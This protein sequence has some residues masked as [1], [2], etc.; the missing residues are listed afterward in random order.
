LSTYDPLGRRITKSWQGA[1]TEYHWDHHRLAAERA[2]DGAVRVYVYADADA[3]VPFMFVDYESDDAPA[4]SGRRYFLFTNQIGAPIRVDEERGATVWEADVDPY[5]ATAVRPESTIDLA[6]RFPGHYE[7]REIGLFYNRFRHYSP[8]L[9]RYLQSDPMGAAGGVNLYAYPANPLTT[10]DLFGLHPPKDEDDEGATTTG[11]DDEEAPKPRPLTPEEEEL[12]KQLVAATRE[13]AQDII[14][15]PTRSKTQAKKDPVLTGVIDPDFPEDGP[16][17]GRNTGLPDDLVDPLAKRIEA[18]QAEVD[19]AAAEGRQIA[20]PQA[21]KPDDGHS[22][23]NALNKALK[24]RE[25]RTGQ[26]ATDA[27]IDDMIGHNVNLID[28]KAK[29]DDGSTTSIPAGT[30]CPPRCDHCRPLTSGV[31][32][33]DQ[34]G[35]VTDE[36]PKPASAPGTSPTPAGDPTPSTDPPPGG[37]PPPQTDE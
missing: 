7:D 20:K 33:V 15:D 24:N 8:V 26:P 36:P 37:D 25:D 27:D 14:D 3:L 32:M 31:R 34:N 11:K 1:T 19:K 2:P 30:G 35:Q 10:V 6:L 23:I 5:G 9:G 4:A 28:K 16:F 12:A 18:R 21:G 29:Q 22:E 13:A 17:L